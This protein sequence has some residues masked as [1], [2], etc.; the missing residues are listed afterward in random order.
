MIF[1]T[2]KL[3]TY[4]ICDKHNWQYSCGINICN[5]MENQFH[6]KSNFNR[7]KFQK[8]TRLCAC[9]IVCFVKGSHLV[10]MTICHQKITL[11]LHYSTSLPTWPLIYTMAKK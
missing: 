6:G 9:E 7:F 1:Y 4:V 5:F 11:N 10:G 3:Q 8:L 2:F